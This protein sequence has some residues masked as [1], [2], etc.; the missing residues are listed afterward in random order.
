MPGNRRMWQILRWS[1][2]C[3]QTFGC[4]W[5]TSG[6]SNYWVDDI[7]FKWCSA[8]AHLKEN[9]LNSSWIFFRRGR[10]GSE[11]ECVKSILL[12]NSLISW[13][14]WLSGLIDYMNS[15][16]CMNSTAIDDFIWIQ[17]T[18]ACFHMNSF[19]I[20]IH[21]N[22]P[23]LHSPK[24]PTIAQK[25]KRCGKKRT[26]AANPKHKEKIKRKWLLEKLDAVD[27]D[28]IPDNAN[29]KEPLENIRKKNGKIL[30]RGLK[31]E[32][33]TR[34]F[35]LLTWSLSQSQIMV[36]PMAVLTP[37]YPFH[38]WWMKWMTRNLNVNHLWLSIILL[39]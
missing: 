22:L 34:L 31:R 14:H 11:S 4:S 16:D 26:K 10:D 1:L 37:Y 25:K 12:L 39:K 38:F 27:E 2:S 30:L 19:N 21:W 24:L 33:P 35:L 8:R 29:Q 15:I 23:W 9:R 13:I 3:S 20:W 18:H 36:L 17:L 5:K 6:G 7:Y 28:F 32:T